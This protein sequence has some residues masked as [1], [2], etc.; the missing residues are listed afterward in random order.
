MIIQEWWEC[1][2]NKVLQYVLKL[3][4]WEPGRD[5]QLCACSVNYTEQQLKIWKDL[6]VYTEIWFY[7]ELSKAVFRSC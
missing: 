5:M 2:R 1:A 7:L 3:I 4:K 6:F